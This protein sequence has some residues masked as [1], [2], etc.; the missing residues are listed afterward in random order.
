MSFDAA[1]QPIE[2][3]PQALLN[4]ER[5][6]QLHEEVRALARQQLLRTKVEESI[7]PVTMGETLRRFIEQVTGSPV[8]SAVRSAV[9]KRL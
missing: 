1:N 3:Q 9:N 6:W 2:V 4:E 5:A 8:P 7:N